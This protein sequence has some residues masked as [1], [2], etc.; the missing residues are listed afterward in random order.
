MG[1]QFA[2]LLV[3]VYTRS[4]NIMVKEKTNLQKFV[5]LLREIDAEAVSKCKGKLCDKSLHVC[6]HFN[7]VKAQK[8]LEYARKREIVIPDKYKKILEMKKD[9][10]E[11]SQTLSSKGG[12]HNKF[13]LGEVGEPDK[14]PGNGD[15]SLG[16]PFLRSVY[17]DKL[18]SAIDQPSIP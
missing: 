18:V 9:A 16:S 8:V 17:F 1:Y 11:M 13:T 14:S 3:K 6:K 7:S 15:K 5:D 4:P 10:L 2:H 12:K